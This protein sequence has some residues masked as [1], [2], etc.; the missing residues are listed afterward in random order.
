MNILI[1]DSWLREYLKT[2]ATPIQIK[3]CLSLCGPSIEQI[4]YINNEAV[5][6]IELTT[7][8]VDCMNIMGIARE[9]AAI[10]P[11]FGIKAEFLSFPKPHLNIPKKAL[12]IKIDNNKN[13]CRRILAI[14][15]KDVKLGPSPLWLQKRLELVGQRPLNNVIDITNYVMWELGHPTHA[16]DYDRLKNK[17]IIV[18]LAKK[19]EKANTLD[20]KTHTMIGGEIIF[21]NGTGQ[22]ID[23]P[24]IM[25]TSN[26]VITNKTKNVLL[27][28]E[29]SDPSKIRF[30]SMTHAIRTRA[31]ILNE[32]DPDPELAKDAMLRMIELI[33]KITQGKAASSLIDMYPL[34]P[35]INT[36]FLSQKLLESYVGIKIPF[37]HVKKILINLGFDVK[38]KSGIMPQYAI[39]PPSWRRADINIPQDVIEE[40]TRVYGYH[41]LPSSIP[42]GKIPLVKRDPTLFWEEEIKI[43]LRDWGYTEVLTYSMISEKL[44]DLFAFDKKRSYVIT[45]P[46]SSDWLYMRPNIF[47]SMLFTIRKNLNIKSDLKLFELSMSYKYREN[48]IPLETPTL[49]VLWTGS[50][51]REAKGL[52]E[53]LF[54]LFGIE[55]PYKST[56]ED[57]QVLKIYN[58]K[59]FFLGE[60]GSL[61][62][63]NQDLL[64]KTEIHTPVT[65]LT[66]DFY[67]LVTSASPHTSY[68]PISKY[69]P[70]YEDIALIVP[71]SVS[72]G[73][74]IH[75]IQKSHSLIFSVTL[76]DSYKNTRTF[77]I[78]Y[79]D[80][81]KNLIADDIRPIREKILYTV[82]KQFGARLKT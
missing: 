47:P 57:K 18:R 15:I 30:T 14:Y 72:M 6:N 3:D 71:P 56:S 81:S 19:G 17:T 80:R 39:K 51:Y 16:F 1:P 55:F 27:F 4:S 64:S 7:N 62:E 76:L 82:N 22:I 54:K 5:Y 26:T 29:N 70:A 49:V 58:E 40:I 10:L 35:K 67:K 48:N 34:K 60:F 77:H 46:L 38:Y 36:I 41:N 59:C 74:L 53:S 45:N 78:T 24:G 12:D 37:K 63:I 73:S 61:G 25:G 75:A 43:R 2:K 31:A 42:E 66:L 23:I 79:V 33:Q 32:K 28:I 65:T 8:R 52:A 11:E 9:A 44:M 69:P 21:D 68:V 13:L 20:E 50:K